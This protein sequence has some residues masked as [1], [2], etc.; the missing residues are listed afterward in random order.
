M[1][2]AACGAYADEIY[3]Y[4]QDAYFFIETYTDIYYRYSTQLR[5]R[6][7]GGIDI[8][9]SGS[10]TNGGF[11]VG[12]DIE[13]FQI[14]V[15]SAFFDAGDF[16]M[17]NFSFRFEIPACDYWIQ[18][19]LSVQVGWAHIEYDDEL[20]YVGDDSVSYGVGI[21]AKFL[22]NKNSFAKI[23]LNYSYM[24]FDDHI[25]ALDLDVK[26]RGVSLSGAVGYRF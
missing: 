3:E 13:N 18:P 11:A 15:T 24:A 12:Y 26:N 4:N 14:A 21:G 25:D 19:Y 5:M 6:H 2:L 20:L 7:V 9:S 10:G 16:N 1:I 22:L 8:K 23:S 17:S